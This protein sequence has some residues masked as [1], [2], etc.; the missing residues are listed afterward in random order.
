MMLVLI[1]TVNKDVKQ[2]AYDLIGNP[3]YTVAAT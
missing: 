1:H 2:F 3:P